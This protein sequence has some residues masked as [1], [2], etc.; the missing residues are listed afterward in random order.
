[1]KRDRLNSISLNHIRINDSFWNRYTSLVSDKILPYQWE[2]LNDRVEGAEKSHCIRNFEIAAGRAAG[3]FHGFVFQDT[4]LAKWIEAAAYTL[5]FFHNN[6][7]QDT[8]DA[9]IEL[10]AA[11]QSPD[12]Y[13]NTYFTVKEPK[14][15]FKNLSEGHELY[16]AGHM[17]E[18]AV[19]Y[20]EVTG[21]DRFLKIMCKMADLLCDVF[22]SEEYENAVPGHQEVEIG[23]IKLYRVTGERKYLDLAKAFIDRRGT[24][25]NYLATEKLKPDWI[26]VFHNPDPFIPEYAQCDE[27]VRMQKT[28]RG[29]AVRAVYMYSAMADLAYEYDDEELLTVCKTLYDDITCKQMYITGGI[30]QSGLY[31][32]FTVGYDLPNDRN[33]S[34]TCASIGLALFCRRMA[35][36][37]HEEKYLSTMETALFNTVLAGVSLDGE[38]FF[39]VNPL[40]VW[41][42]NLIPYTSLAHIKPVRQKWFPCACCPPNIARTLASLGEYVLFTDDDSLWINMYVGC[43]C[44]TKLGGV[45]V[46][47]TVESR[48]PFAGKALVKVHATE[49]FE[50]RL[51]LRI[52]EYTSD[53]RIRCDCGGEIRE[54]GVAKGGVYQEIPLTY[55]GDGEYDISVMLDF[56]MP[57]RFIYANSRVQADAGKVAVVKGPVVYAAE[58]I[59]NGRDLSEFIVDTGM[60]IQEEYDTDLMGGCMTLT[61]S[62]YRQVSTDKSVLYG[63]RPPET[64]PAKLKLIPYAYWNN[65]GIGEMRVWIRHM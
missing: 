27:P 14:G 9:A 8:V 40:E 50:G 53:C 21:K 5:S 33:Y 16:T 49:P 37:T 41:P 4:D 30:G 20:Y 60:G 12:G 61:L 47:L 2:I 55:K 3:E 25:P 56:E 19:A 38:S 48:L 7:L 44:E 29:H 11:A 35:Q 43:Q 57:A 13:I 22:N 65:R 52:P 18:A 28:A 59:D 46:T 31:E 34:E 62:G 39:Y 32:R 64:V 17:M 10:I 51:M 6:T 26:D 24:N 63:T 15:R 58:E 36:I 45:P 54:C 1:M 23:L 42:D